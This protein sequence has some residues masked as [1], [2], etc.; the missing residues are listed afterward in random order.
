MD[1]KY[2]FVTGGVVSGLGKG[3][4]AASLGRL[5]KARGL[6]VTAQKLDP[7]LNV[8]PGTMNPIQHGEV[9][10]TDDG[11][12]TDLDLGHYERFIDESLSQN[13][14]L[15]SGRV[16]WKV[17]TDERKGVYG[18][19]TIQVIPHVTNEI[20][21][22]IQKNAESGA[23]VSIVEIGGT[24]GDIESQPF[25]EA[26]RQFAVEAGR[27]NC[28]F[29]HVT[30][31]PYLSA[32]N[33]LKSKPTQHSVKEMLSLGLHPDIIVCRTE[34]PLTDDI[35]RKIA[36]FCNVDAACIIENR[37]CDLLYGIPLMMEDEGL[38]K[39]AIQKL[40]LQCAAEP[41]LTDWKEM[42]H[43]LRHPKQEVKIALV[44]KYVE[45]HDSYISVN[46]ALKHGGIATR[47][48]VDIHWIDSETLEA[49][50]C[51]LN[52]VLGDMDGILVPGGFGSRGIEGKIKA[53]H[54][55]R[56]NGVPYLGICLG[57]QVAIIEFA[58]N[59][60]GFADANSAEIDP[61]TTHPVIDILPE[62]KD[63]QEMGGTMRLGQYPCVLNP[64]SKSFA[65][66]QS[67]MIYERHRHRYEVNNDY[68][69]DLA[70]NGMLL[71]GTS[72]DNHIVEMVELPDHPWFVAAQFH[73]EFKS[74]PN[75]PHPLFRGFVTAAAERHAKKEKEA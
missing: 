16:Y 74:R 8:D 6:K 11:A 67:S 32:S 68:R 30:L 14:N 17:I 73:P 24:V 29:I 40:G 3:I 44:G 72:P 22:Y 2:V 35:K 51:D 59:V 52:A 65:L 36:L 37:D 49:P 21:K 42:V 18:G 9:F 20:K 62:Q 39:V 15:T 70:K 33:E 27:E 12:E 26:I 46:E 53:V 38:A 69:D 57:M 5:L 43:A 54:Y 4:T 63:V 66:Y 48:K 7:Y 47:S 31:V 58:R 34:H 1:K 28:L 61:A 64:E 19:Q 56:T 13:S 71:A 10:V 75:K 23:D 55:A 25:L 60:L 41:D 50:D 45:L